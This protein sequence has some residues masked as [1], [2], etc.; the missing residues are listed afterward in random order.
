MN[1]R[2]VATVAAV[3]MILGGCSHLV[4]LHDALTAA[5]HNDLGV[6][7]EA[8]GDTVAAGREYRRALRRDSRFGR[9][10]VN[11][12]NLEARRGRWTAAERR[13]RHALRVM[14]GD[15][16]ALNNLAVV[17]LRSG[18][19]LDEAERLARSA[20]LAAGERD[21]IPRATLAEVQAARR[22]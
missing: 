3:V 20:A 12:G 9:A 18:R 4:V 17:L 6:V 8:A 14:P 19:K 21:S 10:I 7:Y 13:Y 1:P 11:L 15:P 22:R 16:D 2:R 5:E